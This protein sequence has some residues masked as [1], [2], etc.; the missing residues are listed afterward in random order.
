MDLEYLCS[1]GNL[2][3]F[4]SVSSAPPA[5]RFPCFVFDPI[6]TLSSV[7][8]AFVMMDAA[9]SLAVHSFSHRVCERK[10]NRS[11]IW[12]P[13][14]VVARGL[15]FNVGCNEVQERWRMCS[16]NGQ[17]SIFPV[18]VHFDGAAIHLPSMMMRISL[19]YPNHVV[20]RG[21]VE[22]QRE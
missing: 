6:V 9:R 14:P 13:F 19:D 7:Q 8:R 2:F 5:L 22:V 16:R 11:C 10:V 12:F 18:G 20:Q 1:L 15:H 4:S 17:F 3:P 21:K